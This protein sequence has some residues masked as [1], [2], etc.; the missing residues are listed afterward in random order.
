MGADGIKTLW[1]TAMTDVNA[2]AKSGVPT[3]VY[4]K[5]NE[6]WRTLGQVSVQVAA[7]VEMPTSWDLA[8]DSVKD[9]VSNLPDTLGHAAS[10]AAH[11][12]GSA[13]VAVGDGLLSLLKKPLYLG[14]GLVGLYLFARNRG[15][16]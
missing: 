12:V 13:A 5:N 8:V 16:H 9:S 1:S 2:L 6:F 15:E 14:A 4:A 10:S 7:A 11:A 3:D